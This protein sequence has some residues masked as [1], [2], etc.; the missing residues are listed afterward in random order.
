MS[1]NQLD[2]SIFDKFNFERKPIGVRYSFIKP[3]G[4]PRIDKSM[5]ICEMFGAAQEMDPFYALPE[6]IMCGTQVLGIEEY[7]PKMYSGQLGPLFCM[8][9]TPGANRRIY[10]YVP[11][12]AKDSVYYFTHATYDKM[13]YD[14][15]FMIFTTSVTQAEVILR[16]SS[17]SD[18]KMWNFKGTTCLACAWIYAHPFLTGQLNFS[19]SGLGFSMK[20]RQALPEGLMIITVP[21]DQLPMLIENLKDMEWDP[22]WFHL[23]REGFHEE[24]RKREAELEKKFY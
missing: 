8:F 22:Y 1:E 10:D 3:E 20:A 9:K 13:N 19:V 15:D 6:D 7:P 14:P 21:F 4:I 12:L 5:A 11:H 18:G 24:V 17:Y 16:A 23:G 2:Y